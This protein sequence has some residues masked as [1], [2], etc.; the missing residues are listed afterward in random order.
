MAAVPSYVVSVSRPEVA[1]RWTSV[2][3]IPL[4]ILAMAWTAPFVILAVGIPIAVAVSLLN[5]IG[6]FLVSYFFPAAS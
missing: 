3:L 5:G 2:I 6:R 1:W 4:E